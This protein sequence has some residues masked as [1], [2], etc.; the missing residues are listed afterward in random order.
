M[1]SLRY[2]RVKLVTKCMTSMSFHGR[3][4]YSLLYADFRRVK[5]FFVLDFTLLRLDSKKSSALESIKQ[6]NLNKSWSKWM[7]AQCSLKY[8]PSKFGDPAH[9]KDKYRNDDFN[10]ATICN[11]KFPFNFKSIVLG[12]TWSERATSHLC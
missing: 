1:I 12:W 2:H 8:Q 6:L 11:S 9:N 3:L 4:K 10:V 5:L 7:H